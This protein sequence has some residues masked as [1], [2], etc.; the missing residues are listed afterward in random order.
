MSQYAVTGAQAMCT[1]GTTPSA[2]ATTSSPT[3]TIGGM[4]AGTIMDNAP[5]ANV[6]PFGMCMTP[7]N[8]QVAAATAAASGVLTPQPCIPNTP[9]PWAPGAPT[10]LIGNKPALT[11]TCKLFCAYGGVIS[12]TMPGQMT[13]QGP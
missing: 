4:P 2:V 9:G 12:L 3:T 11:N 7:T 6:L 5:M 13:V 1:F 8:P 10:V